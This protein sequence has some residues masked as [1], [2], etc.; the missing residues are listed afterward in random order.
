MK[1]KSLSRDDQIF[2]TDTIFPKSVKA[3]TIVPVGDS[4]ELIGEWVDSGSNCPSEIMSTEAAWQK[5][6]L[7]DDF[8][9]NLLFTIYR[10]FRMPEN[11]ETN[12][13]RI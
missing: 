4:I 5:E 11:W 10:V 1:C 13:R 8:I 12:K 2:V 3:I 6:R 7:K 9:C